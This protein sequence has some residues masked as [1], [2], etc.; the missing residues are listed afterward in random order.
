MD[1]KLFKRTGVSVQELRE[2]VVSANAAD[3]LLDVGTS[4]L[5]AKYKQYNELRD[6]AYVLLQEHMLEQEYHVLASH[7]KDSDLA[8]V[9]AWE[10]RRYEKWDWS[11]WAPKYR[12]VPARFEL[13]LRS[14][15]NNVLCGLAYGVPHKKRN[16]LKVKVLEGNP[17]KDHPMKG[18][19]LQAILECAVIY[20]K[21]LK[22]PVLRIQ[23][24]MPELVP[25]YEDFGF[26]S[27]RKG[28]VVRYCERCIIED[29]QDQDLDRND[30]EEY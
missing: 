26:V 16:Y 8:E 28:E 9:L 29:G 17:A 21:L 30:E 22:C 5:D 4:K 15:P 24:P 10:G 18:V 2:I 7:I 19:V 20:A 14:E 13:S 6:A 23:D 1:E 27:T 25:V 11:A 12:S 3:E